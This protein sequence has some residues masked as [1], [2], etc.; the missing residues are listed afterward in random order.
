MAPIDNMY[1]G[2]AAFVTFICTQKSSSTFQFFLFPF[3]VAACI[4]SARR[5]LPHNFLCLHAGVNFPFAIVH[6]LPFTDRGRKNLHS[7]FV[8]LA[9]KNN[10][11]VHTHKATLHRSGVVEIESERDWVSEKEQRSTFHQSTSVFKALFSRLISRAAFVRL[12]YLFPTTI[13]TH[14]SECFIVVR[15]DYCHA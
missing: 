12:N 4:A 1:E 15:L 11:F 2:A 13:A 9:R 8:F 6:Y 3:F 5:I 10:I 7:T 14:A